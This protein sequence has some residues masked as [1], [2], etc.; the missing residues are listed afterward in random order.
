MSYSEFRPQPTSSQVV[1]CFWTLEEDQAVYNSD[2]ILPDSYM[3]LVV[4]FGAPLIL[5]TESGARIEMPRIFLKGLTKKPLRL[6]ATGLAQLVGVRLHPWAMS[7]LFGIEA[8]QANVPIIPHNG[9]ILRDFARA[10]ELSAQRSDLTETVACLQEIVSNTTRSAQVDITPI[11]S[12]IELLYATQGKMRMTEIAAQAYLSSSQFERRFK[13]VTGVSPKTL[14]RLIRFEGVRNRL[15]V[16]PYAS[17]SDLTHDFGYTDQAHLIHDFKAFA[18][19]TPGAFAA[20]VAQQPNAE[21][22]QYT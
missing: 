16:D 15:T 11:Q 20:S 3:E 7:N 18:N 14:T 4:N 1:K 6:R 10:L 19:R 2:E 5:E 13:R 22:L 9:I 17:P 21:F 12:A 8:D